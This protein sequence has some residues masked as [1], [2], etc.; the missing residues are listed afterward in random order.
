MEEI[1]KYLGIFSTSTVVAYGLIRYLS[2]KFFENYLTKRIESHKSELAKLNISHQ[3]QFSSLHKER[4]VVIKN[5]YDFLYNY[6]LAIL[7]FFENELDDKNPKEHLEHKLAEWTK[8]VMAFSTTF[9]QNKIF[10]STNQ[11]ELINTIN[12]EMDKINKDTRIFLSKYSYAEDQIK[13]I[14]E[15]SS[16]FMELK[17]RCDIFLN[18][19]FDLE[20]QLETEFR[21]LLGVEI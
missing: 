15:K 11:V 10:F 14:K 13:E 9:H 18:N 6:K 16:E 21:K 1:F 19:T 12:N 17:S 4:A 2:Q 8:G 5:L 3:I 7:D 20:K